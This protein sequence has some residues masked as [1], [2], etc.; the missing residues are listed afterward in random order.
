MTRNLIG[1]VL[2]VSSP[3]LACANVDSI[4]NGETDEASGTAEQAIWNSTTTTTHST[5]V[6]Y[7]GYSNGTEA[8]GYIIHQNVLL[9]TA[10]TLPSNTADKGLVGV[11]IA[12]KTGSVWTCRSNANGALTTAS[13]P[14]SAC[15]SFGNA[16][17]RKDPAFAGTHVH[18]IAALIPT[19]NQYSWTTSTFGGYLTFDPGF[20]GNNQSVMAYAIGG[21]WRAEGASLN[22]RKAEINVASYSVGSTYMRLDGAGSYFCKGDEGSPV[23]PITS[24]GTEMNAALGL[25]TGF[26]PAW[27][28]E[29]SQSGIEQR[30]T[31]IG[32]SYDWLR[33]TLFGGNYC[34]YFW[35]NGQ[36]NIVD[37]NYSVAWV[38]G[39]MVRGPMP[40]P[41][42]Y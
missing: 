39:D 7:V 22:L 27:D 19:N 11:K 30:I 23:F 12:V 21:N 5:D 1:L 18:D 9:T 35:V 38:P 28:G 32:P 31:L 36:S 10:T 26:A 8:N 42:R 25:R 29:C 37:C 17:V 16:R 15:A 3:L 33:N 34:Y 2:I 6:A 14:R 20:F 40:G 4:D 13:N 41:T 24:S